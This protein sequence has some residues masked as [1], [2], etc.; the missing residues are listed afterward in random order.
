MYNHEMNGNFP[1]SG[2]EPKPYDVVAKTDINRRKIEDSLIKVLSALTSMTSAER[3]LWREKF[4]KMLK[5]IQCVWLLRN[6]LKKNPYHRE[7][8]DRRDTHNI[9]FTPGPMYH[10]QPPPQLSTHQTSHLERM[11]A[12]HTTPIPYPSMSTA[13]PPGVEGAVCPTPIP[14]GVGGGGYVSSYYDEGRSSF[15]IL[16]RGNSGVGDPSLNF[17]RREEKYQTRNP[18]VQVRHGVGS[19]HNMLSPSDG[20]ADPP[21]RGGAA[22]TPNDGLMSERRATLFEPDPIGSGNDQD[23]RQR[24]A[25]RASAF[26]LAGQASGTPRANRADLSAVEYTEFADLMVS[27]I[28]ENESV[29]STGS[30]QAHGSDTSSMRTLGSLGSSLPFDDANDQQQQAGPA[31]TENL[32]ARRGESTVLTEEQLQIREMTDRMAQLQQTTRATMQQ[33]QEQNVLL[34]SQ[35]SVISHQA[36]RAEQRA[37]HVEGTFAMGGELLISN[38]GAEDWIVD[39][40]LSSDLEDPYLFW[41]VA[42]NEWETPWQN[43]IRMRVFNY[44]CTL[45]PSEVFTE[46]FLGDIKAI[47]NNVVSLGRLN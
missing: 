1:L 41:D 20:K 23:G 4:V 28:P 39:A 42:R 15:P 34:H 38:Q 9:P 16:P 43:Q 33:L 32:H 30:N 10:R 45:L 27:H 19:S 14:S 37:I 24:H 29:H 47:Y 31:A 40:I 26:S 2:Y 44:I 17:Q 8:G 35:L 5:T 11:H 13:A 36:Q 6:L 18:Y 25:G 21:H 3:Q 22:T 12:R 7:V 46:V